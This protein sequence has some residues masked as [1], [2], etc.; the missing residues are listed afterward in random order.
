MCSF[1]SYMLGLF[2]DIDVNFAILRRVNRWERH[3]K[4]KI[5][6]CDEGCDPE[7]EPVKSHELLSTDV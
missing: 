2:S 5:K 7:S 6:G 3:E 4:W 1:L